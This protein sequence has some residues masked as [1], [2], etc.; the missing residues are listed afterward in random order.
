MLGLI[1]EKITGMTLEDWYQEH[2]FKPLGMKDTSYAVAA[3][4]QSRVA[5]VHVRAN[6]V[7]KQ[8]SPRTPIA[9]DAGAALSRRRRSVFDGA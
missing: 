4:K 6:G 9:S 3:D 7:I 1:V 2:I 5:A 8:R